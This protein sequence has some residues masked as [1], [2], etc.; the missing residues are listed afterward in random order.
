MK[1][2]LIFHRPSARIPVSSSRLPSSGFTLLELLISVTILGI[3]MVG[4]YQVM[5]V[6]LSA[7]AVRENKQ[8]LVGRA[9]FAM[10]RMV[11]FAQETS[12]IDFPN[13]NELELTERVLDVYDNATLG[14]LADGDGIP[15]SD[16]DQ[17]GLIDE[18]AGDDPETVRFKFYPGIFQLKERL[19][20][21]ST[22]DQSDYRP[23]T[24][25]CEDAA[26]VEFEKLAGNLAQIILT[27]DDG[28]GQVTLKTRVIA[29]FA[30]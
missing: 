9:S 28:E 7:Y 18:G 24:V 20:D 6:A 13:P 15:D 12:K 5:G 2:G 17:D 11:K 22:A 25:I 19:P 29:R 30:D 1:F 16:V 21:Y 26:N 8:E 23:E 14:Y 10:E 4:L 3:I 27:L